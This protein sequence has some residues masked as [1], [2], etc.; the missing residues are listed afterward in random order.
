MSAAIL[1]AEEPLSVGDQVEIVADGWPHDR[2]G[3]KVAP[4]NGE[5]TWDGVLVE[6]EQGYRHIFHRHEV[7]KF[8]TRATS[9]K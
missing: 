5:V 4:R 8:W 3:R 9:P 1:E 2:F 6:T 7:Q